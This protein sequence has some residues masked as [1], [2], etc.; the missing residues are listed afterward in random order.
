M[1]GGRQGRQGKAGEGRG[2]QGKAGEGSN[3]ANSDL[4]SLLSGYLNTENGVENT[5][6]SGVFLTKFEVLGSDS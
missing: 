6:R 5:T 1:Y 4:L 3:P 2:R